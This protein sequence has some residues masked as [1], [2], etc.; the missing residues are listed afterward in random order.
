MKKKY[1]VIILLAC[2]CAAGGCSRETGPTSFD[3]ILDK[4]RHA[5]NFSEAKR[6][7]TGG[8][9]DAIDASVSDGV[10]A[11]K[12]RLRILPLFSDKDQMGRGLEE[13]RGL[14]RDGPDTIHR[15]P[16]GK[17]DRLRDGLSKSGKKGGAWKI[18]LEQEIRQAAAGPREH[19]SPARV[20]TADIKTEVLNNS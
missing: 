7:Y 4:L 14:P 10:I 20:Y 19:G 1:Y 11:E 5:R 16:G 18:D 15:A 9:I 6:Y 12:E 3:G 2:F 13:G 8:T 17:H